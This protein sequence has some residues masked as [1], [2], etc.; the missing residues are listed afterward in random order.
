[1]TLRKGGV[2]NVGMCVFVCMRVCVCVGGSGC[3]SL[4]ERKRERK[5]ANKKKKWLK[6]K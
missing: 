1:M 4:I 3:V 2:E 5:R 6:D